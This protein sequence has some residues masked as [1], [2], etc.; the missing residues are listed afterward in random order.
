MKWLI[1]TGLDIFGNKASIIFSIFVF[2][3]LV[4]AAYNWKQNY[5]EK[6]VERTNN[7]HKAAELERAEQARDIY[8]ASVSK[9]MDNQAKD[10]QEMAQLQTYSETQGALINEA[11]NQLNGLDAGDTVMPTNRQRVL[12]ITLQKLQA[13]ADADIPADSEGTAPGRAVEELR[14]LILRDNDGAIAEREG[15]DK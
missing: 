10:Q 1:K 13:T 2:G 11:L 14:H 8:A 6:I 12:A 3:W 5:D 15:N 7:V 4:T 9:M